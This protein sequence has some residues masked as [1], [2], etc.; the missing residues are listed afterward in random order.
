[1]ASWM[2]LNTV[3]TPVLNHSW[4]KQANMPHIYAP[5]IFFEEQ[6]LKKHWLWLVVLLAP[7]CFLAYTLLYQLYTGKLIGDHPS[8]NINI[9]V[10]LLFYGVMVY[11]ALF[12]VKLSTII[13]SDK[14]C[15]GWNLPT[16]QLKEIR[17]ADIKSCSLI[18]YHFVGYG[19]RL[20]FKYGQ[21]Y[22][23]WGNKGLFIVKKNGKKILLGTNSAKQLEEAL[24][25]IPLLNKQ[26]AWFGFIA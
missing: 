4:V 22:N 8:S 1:M 16:N 23:V 17:I 10:L 13:S 18:T 26:S 3:T 12:Y 15:Y 5:T 7:F 2:P 14:I 24:K 6:Q 11:F 21:V 9:S 20:S 25:K 19:Y